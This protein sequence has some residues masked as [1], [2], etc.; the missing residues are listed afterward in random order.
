MVSHTPSGNLRGTW[1]AEWLRSI[2]ELADLDMQRATWVNP[3]NPNPHDSFVE[4]VECYFD[5]LG[6]TEQD[7]GYSARIA[8]GLLSPAE[9][10]AVSEFH[11]LFDH[12]E[13]PNGD[14]DA[15]AVLDDPAWQRVVDA[16]KDAQHRLTRIIDDPDERIYLLLPA[17]V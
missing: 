2:Q 8:E 12:Y 9:A 5:D 13:P 14:S 1:R 10:A 3:A 16:A 11:A 4:Y 15:Q 6:L 7:G 17:F